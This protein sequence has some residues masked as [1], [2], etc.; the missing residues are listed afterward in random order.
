MSDVSEKLFLMMKHKCVG[1]KTYKRGLQ[2]TS[3]HS[4]C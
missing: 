3:S 1:D 2:Y 4:S